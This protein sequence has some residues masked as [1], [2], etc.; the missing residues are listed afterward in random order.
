MSFLMHNTQLFFSPG[1]PVN[2]HLCCAVTAGLHDVRKK[3]VNLCKLKVPENRKTRLKDI[4]MHNYT[5][6]NYE[7]KV[8]DYYIFYNNP[9]FC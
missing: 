6:N 1:L 2:S 4:M 5:I 9:I 8:Q 7:A 3:S